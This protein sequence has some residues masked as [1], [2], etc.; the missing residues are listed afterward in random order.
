MLFEHPTWSLELIDRMRGRDV[1][2]TAIDVGDAGV[3]WLGTGPEFDLWINRVNALPSAG[4]APTVAAATRHLLLS[5]ELRGQRIVNGSRSQSIGAS[6]LAQA[7]IFAQLGLHTPATIGIHQPIEVE[8]AAV[9]LG[10]PVLIKPNIG[11]SGKGIERFDTRADLLAALADDRVDL[12][13][14]GTGVVQSVIAS[15]DG[16]VHRIEMLGG[17][18]LYAIDQPAQ[19]GV[20]NYCAVDGGPITDDQHSIEFVTPSARIVESAARIMSAASTD[21]GSVEYLID[22]ATGEPCYFDFNPY[23]NL[24]KGR[25]AELGFDPIEVFLDAILQP[26]G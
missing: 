26:I 18:L 10:F 3:H 25:D 8:S 13:V 5:L 23:S 6:K 21:V 17:E 11:G 15:A 14:D 2:V 4:R 20:Y 24:I 7:A 19:D 9:Q 16:L 1:E 22:G 12:G